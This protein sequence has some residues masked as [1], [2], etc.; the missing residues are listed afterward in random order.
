MI[1]YLHVCLREG[2]R[3]PET[4]MTDSYELPCGCW[5]LNP[6]PLEEQPVVLTTEPS[7]SLTSDFEI[8]AVS[9]VVFRRADVCGCFLG[10]P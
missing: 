6:G 5:E 9:D 2:V 7:L 8:N 4:G 3:S 1:F 10:T